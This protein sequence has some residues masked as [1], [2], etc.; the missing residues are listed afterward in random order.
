MGDLLAHVYG[1]LGEL[2]G[3]DKISAHGVV[4]PAVD[5]ANVNG[6]GAALHIK[7]LGSYN[8]SVS[9]GR[10]SLQDYIEARHKPDACPDTKF[11]IAGYSQGAQAA[12]DALQRM[13][14]ADRQLVVAAAF[15]GDPYFNADSLSSQ[16]SDG[17]HYGSLGVRDEWPDT[18]AGKVFSYCRPHDP[19]CAISDKHHILGDGDLYT[20]NFFWANNMAP[21]SEYVTSGD[22]DDA[23]RKIAR[24]L[25]VRTP[26]SGTV[27]LDL[28][29]AIDT[30]GSMGGT[31]SQV[32]ANVTSLAQ[33]IAA[34]ST[35]YRF[36]LVD[37]KDGADQGDPYRAQVDLGFT[38]DVTSFANAAAALGANGGG[39]T[40][41]SVYSGIMTGLDLPWRNGVRKVVIAIGDAPGKDPEP[42]TGYTLATVRDR[43]L[44]VDPA[45]V[46]TVATSSD[47]S[48]NDFLAAIA[49]ATGGQHASAPDPDA[50]VSTLQ[51]TIVSAG[52]APIADAG[53]PYTAIA[54]DPAQLAATGSRDESENIVGYDWD[55]NADGS[56]DETTTNG[57]V[58]HTYTE[59]GTQMFVVRVRAESGLAGTATATVAVNAAPAPPSTPTGLTATGGDTTISLSWT[60][61]SAGGVP[62][63]YTIYDG[64]GTVVDRVTAQPDGSP[65]SAWIDGLL[66][67]GTLHTYKVSAGNPAGESGTAGPVTATPTAPNQAPTA[68]PDTYTT[69]NQTP[70]QV[71]APGVLTNDTDPNTGDTLTAKVATTPAHGSLTLQPDGSFTYTANTGYVGPDAFTYIA[72][73]S[74]G[75]ASTPATVSITVTAAETRAQRIVF[76]GTGKPPIVLADRTLTGKFTVKKSGSRVETI[77][78]TAT[79]Q[80]GR[81]KQATLTLDVRRSGTRWQA[82]ARVTL[83]DGTTRTYTGTGTV[84]A[85]DRIT[86]GGFASGKTKFGITIIEPIKHR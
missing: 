18:M 17:T 67:N 20:R 19:I 33:S 2:V 40:P 70:L 81:G 26:S 42:E 24:V 55:F 61:G 16:A 58:R 71:P 74:R 49:A 57:I 80:A 66:T 4:Y 84:L 6:V 85:R 12:G 79:I 82:T 73:D 51:S 54:G 62:G 3:K 50:F 14:L 83:A 31:I 35:N 69:D 47:S 41:E 1:K 45:Q 75:L 22:A 13:P 52:S 11:I 10:K 76:V 53:G 28:V 38:T 37:Y 36:A 68:T 65:P 77:T 64:S 46:Y 78:G 32:S 44:A 5:V 29:F 48:A 21:H 8:D 23:A 7:Y 63:W 72:T 15:F 59:V 60:K 9:T 27:P 34:T 56:Y 43:A 25:G 30:T 86:V 39:D